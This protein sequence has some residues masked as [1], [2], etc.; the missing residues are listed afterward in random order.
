MADGYLSTDQVY[1]GDGPLG[2]NSTQFIAVAP[3]EVSLYTFYN[4]LGN[5]DKDFVR[6]I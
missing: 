1:F 2:L 3:D 5:E 6:S 4:F